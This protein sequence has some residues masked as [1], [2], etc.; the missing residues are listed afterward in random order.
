MYFALP[1]EYR[2]S[3]PDE[4]KN[5][6]KEAKE[7]L[8]KSAIILTHHYQRAEIVEFGDAVGDCL[9]SQK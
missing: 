8:G 7:K 2:Q 3:S 1:E 9:P 5:R 4:L 6:I